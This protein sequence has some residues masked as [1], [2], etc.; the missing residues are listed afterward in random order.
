MTNNMAVSAE[1]WQAIALYTRS[2]ILR[3]AENFGHRNAAARASARW[4]HS[5][6]VL[7]NLDQILAG[8]GVPA[9]LQTICRVAA[10]MHDI[11]HYTVEAA[12]HAQRG[13]ETAGK[14]LL[15][16]GFDASFV[17]QVRHIIAGHHLDLDDD[18][19]L[20]DLVQEII[21]THTYPTRLVMDADTLDK[22]GA[23]NGLQAIMTMVQNGANLEFTYTRSKAAVADGVSFTVEWSDT[24]AAN[25]WST[26][27]VT[28]QVLSD[29]GTVQQ[30]KASVPTGGQPRRFA[31]L[32]V[33][34]PP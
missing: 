7:R 17:E 23:T 19:P 12:Y 31:H 6:N 4:T 18:S 9:P 11:D 29:N 34:A 3:T 2:Y 15:K 33:T 27:G 14:F 28:Q 26:V 1:Q 10:L 22:V 13:A 32:K 16:Q 20:E 24:L 8:E 5:L 21:A 25:S 30:V